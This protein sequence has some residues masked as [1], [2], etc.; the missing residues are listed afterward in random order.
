MHNGIL[1]EYVAFLCNNHLEC[2]HPKSLLKESSRSR[3]YSRSAVAA[4]R[5]RKPAAVDATALEV[6]VTPTIQIGVVGAIGSLLQEA[7]RIRLRWHCNRK[8]LKLSSDD[9]ALKQHVKLFPTN[10]M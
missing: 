3:V 9:R 4:H 6:L 1:G 10:I 7:G 2:I 5:C 8:E